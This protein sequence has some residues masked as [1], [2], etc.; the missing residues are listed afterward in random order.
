MLYDCP[1]SLGEIVDKV[2]IL[3]IKLAN[4]SDPLRRSHVTKELD[5]LIASF[6]S[7]LL[8]YEHEKTLLLDINSKL[9]SVEDELRELEKIG[10]FDDRFVQLARSVY[11]LNDQRASIKYQINISSESYIVE[12]KSYSSYTSRTLETQ[13]D[14][15]AP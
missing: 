10:N 11:H 13:I 9:W 8:K 5:L 2:T 4:I 3:E 12:Q 1:V 15:R 7:I 14:G 6:S